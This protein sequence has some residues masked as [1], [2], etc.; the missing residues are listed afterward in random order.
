MK[1]AYIVT[2]LTAVMMIVVFYFVARE[3]EDTGAVKTVKIGVVYVGDV[4]N[5]YTHN[6]V[7]AINT[8]ENTYGDGVEILPKYNIAEGTEKEAILEL[9]E[10]DCDIIFGTSFG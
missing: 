8:I 4:S 6:F 7:K 1:K 9:A 5:A 2:F 10:S 3:V